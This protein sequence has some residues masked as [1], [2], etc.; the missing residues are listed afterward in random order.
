MSLSLGLQRNR[1]GIVSIAMHCR[2]R[3]AVEQFQVIQANEDNR[4]ISC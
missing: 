4:L 1:L 3:D 2:P